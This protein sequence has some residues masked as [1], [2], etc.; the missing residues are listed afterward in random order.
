M[1]CISDQRDLP[2]VAHFVQLSLQ[3][4]DLLGQPL[5]MLVNLFYLPVLSGWIPRLP[6]ALLTL[7][8]RLIARFGAF[9]VARSIVALLKFLG[10][11]SV[12]KCEPMALVPRVLA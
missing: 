1:D 6:I 4:F 7:R 12:F 2:T 9:H 8:R 5:Q 10:E 11:S 3:L